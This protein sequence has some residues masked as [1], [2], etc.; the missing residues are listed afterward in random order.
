MTAEDENLLEESSSQDESCESDGNVLFEKPFDWN[1]FLDRG[2][3]GQINGWE[4]NRARSLSGDWITCACG[5]QCDVIPRYESG[6]P[7]DEEL[8]HLGLRFHSC[9]AKENYSFAIHL[10]SEIEARS[11]YLINRIQNET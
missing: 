3:R 9:I 2:N 7:I 11:T 6:C 1:D 10:L 8:Y 5:N 4:L